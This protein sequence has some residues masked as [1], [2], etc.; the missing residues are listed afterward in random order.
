MRERFQ[1]P[2][3]PPV[4]PRS[5]ALLPL[6]VLSLEPDGLLAVLA[7]RHVHAPRPAAHRAVLLERLLVRP[8]GV[9]VDVRRL[10]AVRAAQ[11]GLLRVEVELANHGVSV[12]RG[13]AST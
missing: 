7:P 8:S 5:R 13:R 11:L 2:E 6:F 1:R 10:A 9:D 3:G 4:I 12:A